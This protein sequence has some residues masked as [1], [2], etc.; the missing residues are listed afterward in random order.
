[1]VS[2]DLAFNFE[3][4]EHGGVHR[5]AQIGQGVGGGIQGLRIT[6]FYQPD[7]EVFQ[8]FSMSVF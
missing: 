3:L 5:R 2:T 8:Y 7:L 4:L 6:D 1:M